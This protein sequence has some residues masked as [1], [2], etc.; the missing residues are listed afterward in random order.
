MESLGF[1]WWFNKDAP[2][3]SNMLNRAFIDS[4]PGL[5]V[6]G[7]RTA[8]VNDFDTSPGGVWLVVGGDG[9]DVTDTEGSFSQFRFKAVLPSNLLVFFLARAAHSGTLLPS[10]SVGEMLPSGFFTGEVTGDST[11]AG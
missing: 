10:G 6:F 8:G 5:V 1:E 4:G 9:D 2:L 7:R 3:P 11:L